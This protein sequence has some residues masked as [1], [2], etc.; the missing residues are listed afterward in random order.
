MEPPVY[1]LAGPPAVGKSTTAHALAATFELS[2]HVPVDDLRHLVVGGLALPAP[3]WTDGIARQVALGREA[4]LRVTGTYRAAGYAVVL[5]DFY[6]PLGMREYRG[7]LAGPDVHGIVLLPAE[8]EAR[9]RGA[10]RS[11][12]ALEPAVEMAIGHGY[13][14]LRPLAD[15]LATEGWLV[16]DTSALD[17][18]ST[19]WT[20]RAATAP[21]GHG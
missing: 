8:A 1:V 10:T 6:D 3:G 2:V 16:L 9:R 13:A 5:D 11:A 15:R 17:V 20:I 19:V 4:A 14:I 12:G 7:L 21:A 18:E